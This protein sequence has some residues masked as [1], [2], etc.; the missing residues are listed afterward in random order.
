MDHTES[1][2][3]KIRQK[4]EKFGRKHLSK[5]AKVN[6]TCLVEHNEH[7][8]S[9]HVTDKGHDIHVKAAS[10]NMYKTIDEVITKL[11]AQIE[12]HGIHPQH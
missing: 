12:S 3:E 9:V 10:D 11:E 1:I 7:I 6:W 4:L 8:A 5:N 2:D